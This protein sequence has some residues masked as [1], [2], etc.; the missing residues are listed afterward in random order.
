MTDNL[1]YTSSVPLFSVEPRYLNFYLDKLINF[2]HFILV[3]IKIIQLHFYL[4][5]DDNYRV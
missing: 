1:F 5:Y 3:K 4:Y 2:K